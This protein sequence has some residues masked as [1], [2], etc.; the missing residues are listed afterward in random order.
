MT[1]ENSYDDIIDLP[2]RQSNRYPHMSMRDRAAQFAPFAALTGFDGVIAETGRETQKKIELSESETEKLNRTLMR[3]DEYIRCGE[4]PSINVIYFLP[5][6]RKDGGMYT[7]YTGQLK[8]VDAARHLLIFGGEDSKAILIDD[9]LE[10]N[11]EKK[12]RL[13]TE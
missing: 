3:L 11:I 4:R 5:D 7:K 1:D 13:T 10:I 9:I 12:N 2:Y 8:R 6:T